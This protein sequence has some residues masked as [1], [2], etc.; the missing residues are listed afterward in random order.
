[1]KSF[2]DKT[3]MFVLMHDLRAS[4]Q[5]YECTHI[6]QTTL[7]IHAGHELCTCKRDA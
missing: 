7:P 1:M 5:F 3:E 4:A 6:F 2:L